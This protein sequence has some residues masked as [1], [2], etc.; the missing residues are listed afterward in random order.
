MKLML[1][2]CCTC[3]KRTNSELEHKPTS[4]HTHIHKHM[5]TSTHTHT[6]RRARARPITHSPMHPTVF[7]TSSGRLYFP[8][9]LKHSLSRA[10]IGFISNT[11]LAFN[12]LAPINMKTNRIPPHQKLKLDHATKRPVKR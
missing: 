10:T 3:N 1:F 11:A 9:C 7:S 12:S 2:S 6:Y 8:F 4:T 5:P